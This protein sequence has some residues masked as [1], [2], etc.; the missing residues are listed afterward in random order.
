MKKFWEN[1]FNGSLKLK[2]EKFV[3]LNTE[4]HQCTLL[5]HTT[6]LLPVLSKLYYN[7][8]PIQSQ[9]KKNVDQIKIK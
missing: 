6:L 1:L 9:S 7:V 3:S 4:E 8:F 5:Q 2:N